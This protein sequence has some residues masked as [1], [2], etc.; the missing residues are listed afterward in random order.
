MWCFRS[1]ENLISYQKNIFLLMDSHNQGL[2]EVNLTSIKHI[3]SM[4]NN[5][6]QQS[7]SQSPSSIKIYLLFAVQCFIQIVSS[8]RK[9][10]YRG[11]IS[12]IST[13]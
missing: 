8:P 10:D 6:N 12:P 9:Q 1:A 11:W 4:Q 13:Q 3:D 5:M 7:S 2:L